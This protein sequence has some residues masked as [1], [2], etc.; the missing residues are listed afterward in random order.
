MINGDVT[1]KILGET[2]TLKTGEDGTMT[3]AGDEDMAW[4]A[5]KYIELFDYSPAMGE[6]AIA[7]AEFIVKSLP[8]SEM[9]PIP[10]IEID[11]DVVY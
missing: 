11:P 2:L 8:G 10:E 5:N 3:W 1:I 6:P 4:L 7:L 9:G